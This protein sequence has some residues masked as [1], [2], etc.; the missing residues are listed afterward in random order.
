MIY[1]LSNSGSLAMFAAIG[2]ASSILST[3]GSKRPGRPEGETGSSG[4]AWFPGLASQPALTLDAAVKTKTPFQKFP[5]RKRRLY[6]FS[7]VRP[8]RMIARS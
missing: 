6:K 5:N 8:G 7:L 1:R 3:F 4:G 2:I